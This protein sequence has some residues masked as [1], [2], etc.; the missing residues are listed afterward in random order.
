MKNGYKEYSLER[1]VAY[2]G[3]L[4]FEKV[5][6]RSIVSFWNLGMVQYGGNQLKRSQNQRMCVRNSKRELDDIKTNET[7]EFIRALDRESWRN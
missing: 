3:N 6:E 4:D 5:R 2:I 7:H 1:R